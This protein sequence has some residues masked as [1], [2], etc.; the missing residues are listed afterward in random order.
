VRARFRGEV[1]VLRWSARL[2]KRRG[3]DCRAKLVCATVVLVAALGLGAASA[4]GKTH[5]RAVRHHCKTAAKAHKGH[6]RRPKSCPKAA[7]LALAKVEEIDRRL[8][9]L[10]AMR[11]TLAELATA[12]AAGDADHECPI[13]EALTDAR[14]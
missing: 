7:G 4:G 13:I 10:T 2:V 3:I 12:C 11:Q 8:R 9:T 6:K 14:D 5:L 1:F